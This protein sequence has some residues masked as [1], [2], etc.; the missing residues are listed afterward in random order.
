MHW[1]RTWFRNHCEDWID[2]KGFVDSGH[3]QGEKRG[4]EEKEM[5][6]VSSSQPDDAYLFVERIPRAGV[7]PLPNDEY[8]SSEVR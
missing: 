1:L 4:K 3:I 7:S 5:S 6:L 2:K 8:G